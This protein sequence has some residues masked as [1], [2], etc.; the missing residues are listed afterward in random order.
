M[1][2]LEEAKYY[3]GE[4]FDEKRYFKKI[5]RSL[6]IF[7]KATQAPAVAKLYTKIHR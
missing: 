4:T 5:I 6:F 7:T 1:G 2:I 3:K